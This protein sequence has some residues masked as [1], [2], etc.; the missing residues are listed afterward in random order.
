MMTIKDY[1]QMFAKDKE[2]GREAKKQAMFLIHK[3]EEVHELALCTHGNPQKTVEEF[4]KAVG[5]EE[6]RYC[7]ASMVNGKAWDGRISKRNADWAKTVPDAWDEES[8][9]EMRMYTNRVHTS[10]LN[11][12]ADYMRRECTDREAFEARCDVVLRGA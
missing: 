2:V 11:Q 1:E 4:I 9:T 8:G 7:I 10:H 12:L 5:F 3:F 6:A